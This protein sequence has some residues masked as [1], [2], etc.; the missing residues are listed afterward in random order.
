[1]EKTIKKIEAFLQ[2]LEKE[3]LHGK[4][5]EFR[6]KRIEKLMKKEIPVSEGAI[7]AFHLIPIETFKE[8]KYYNLSTYIDKRQLLSSNIFSGFTRTY[9]FDGLFFFAE[10]RDKKYFTYFQMF[11]NGIIE[12]VK[13]NPIG[14]NGKIL[15]IR[16]IEDGILENT[17]ICLRFQKEFCVN[18]PIIFYLTMLNVEGFKIPDMNNPPF[19]KGRPIDRDE[20]IFEKITIEGYDEN[21]DEVLKRC[22]D[23]IWNSSGYSKSAYYDDSGNR[24]R[25]GTVRKTV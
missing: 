11:F 23:R 24:K 25:K 22:F 6:S 3:K 12:H 16:D 15:Y 4:I 10:D 21:L 14:S 17:K 1:M 5:E 18:P 7:V 19:L 20:L 9:N 8:T 2:N 13:V